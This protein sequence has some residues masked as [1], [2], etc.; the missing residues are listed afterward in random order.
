MVLNRDKV[1]MIVMWTMGSLSAASWKK[2][3]AIGPI[4]FLSTISIIFFARELNMI[5]IGEDTASSLGIN[6]EKRNNFV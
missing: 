6:V 4:I 3:I 2:V 5:S 1:E